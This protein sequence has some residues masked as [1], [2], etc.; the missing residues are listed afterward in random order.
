MHFPDVDVVLRPMQMQTNI[1]FLGAFSQINR[2][3]LLRKGETKY[4]Q[5]KIESKAPNEWF[6]L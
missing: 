3:E 6:T 5:K 2:I 4:E 1:D